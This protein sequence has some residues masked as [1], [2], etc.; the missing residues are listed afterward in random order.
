MYQYYVTEVR[1][2]HAGEY[3]HENYWAYDEDQQK[4]RLKGE[5]KFHEIM[6]KAAVSDF[7]EH[8]AIMFSAQCYPL[9]HA[10]YVHPSEE[11]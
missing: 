6:A 1:K 4:A 10:Y 8:G 5:A 3:E 9:M 11:E 7:A 2:T